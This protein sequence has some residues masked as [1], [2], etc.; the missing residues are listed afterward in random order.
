[1]AVRVH[2]KD[3]DAEAF[4][5][6]FSFLPLHQQPHQLLLPLKTVAGLFAS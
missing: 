2:A 5:R 3:D 1:M 6:R 4:C